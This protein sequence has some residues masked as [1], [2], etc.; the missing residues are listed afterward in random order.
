MS[1]EIARHYDQ[2]L[3]SDLIIQR[4]KDA[5]PD[6][7]DL[8]QLAPVDQLHIGG[9]KASQKLLQRLSQT[10]PT[11][12]LDIGA[13]LGGLMRLS[14]N[15]F[16]ISLIGLDITHDLNRINQRLAYLFDASQPPTLVT[17]DA[18]HLPFSSNH[19]DA[20]VFQHSLLNMPDSRQALNEA[21]RVLKTGGLLLMHEVL[22]GPNH[23][24]M[25]YPVPWARSATQS[26]LLTQEALEQLLRQTGFTNIEVSD[27]SQEALAWR[28]R[29]QT[30]ESAATN[31][32]KT[33]PVSPALILGPEFAQMGGNVMKNL[34]AEA[35][36]VVEVVA[37]KP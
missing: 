27:W 24:E 10:Q 9:I 28:Q 22:Q 12:V 29:Q 16:G 4:L 36:R 26:H 30:K 18:H 20:V 7:P 14:R 31:T 21:V 3:K 17:G 25:R 19:F 37:R 5:Y 8:Y 13:G 6:G 34:E 35:A 15:R 11:A 33:P 2:S 23:S 1:A 32:A